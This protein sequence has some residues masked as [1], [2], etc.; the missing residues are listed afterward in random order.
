MHILVINAGSSS[1]K[2]ALFDMSDEILLLSG[3]VERIGETEGTAVLRSHADNGQSHEESVHA[4]FSDHAVALQQISGYLGTHIGAGQPLAAI[5]HR[6]VHGGEFFH[7]AASIDKGVIDK[8]RQMIPLAPLHNPANLAGIEALSKLYPKVPQAAVFDTAFFHT[9]PPR[10]YRY[11]IP[12]Q[13]YQ[14]H[15]VRRYGFHGISHKYIA[16]TA[17]DYLRKPLNQLRLISLHLGNGASA[18]AIRNGGC[19]DTSMGMTPLEGLV[20]GTR[21]GDID[22]ALPFYMSRNSDMDLNEIE[23]MLNNQSGVKGFCG[24]GDMREVHRLAATGNEQAMLAIELY[25]YR[26]C[27]YIGAYHIAMGGTDA[28]LFTAGIGENDAAIRRL[29]C[30]QLTVLG[31]EIDSQKNEDHD[32]GVSEIS[33]ANSAIKVLVV[34]TNEELEIARQTLQRFQ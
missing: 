18:A 15:H 31:I 26:I 16:D 9:L 11:A 13:W 6:V 17:A 5:G 28:L 24:T 27:K 29:V 32:E 10:A 34:Q 1:I 20:M 23:T 22:P 2:F 19:I 7:S 12:Q 30:T 14:D 33:T 21:C 25:C 8:I 3:N 4:N